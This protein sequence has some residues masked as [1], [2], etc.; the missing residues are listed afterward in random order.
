M[1]GSLRAPIS[2]VSISPRGPAPLLPTICIVLLSWLV[3]SLLPW[4]KLLKLICL[5]CCQDLV[6]G[7]EDMSISS[8]FI[9]FSPW[10]LPALIILPEFPELASANPI[11]TA[12]VLVIPIAVFECLYSQAPTALPVLLVLLILVF[13]PALNCLLKSML[14][15]CSLRGEMLNC[16]L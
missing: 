4:L 3:T 10:P 6:M 11:V 16:C 14:L 8:F 5:E 9:C 1:P 13:G 7:E 12:D 2:P 15:F